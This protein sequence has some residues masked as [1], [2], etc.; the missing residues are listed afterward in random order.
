MVAPGVY[1]RVY[2]KYFDRGDEVLANGNSSSDSWRKG[3]GGFRLDSEASSQNAFTL[4]GDFYSGHNQLPTGGDDQTSGGNLLGRWTHVFS[5]ESN[6]SLQLYYDR[7]H[8]S[9]PV[10]ALVVNKSTL[11]PA[12]IFKDDLDTYDLD[13]QHRF[14]LGGRSHIVWGFGYRFTHDAV[15]N[16]PALAFFPARLDQSLISGFAQDE[17]ALGKD[18][19]L[20][21]GTKLE[22]NDY[23][24]LEVEPSVRLQWAATA[25]QSLW[26]AVSR[27]VRRP[28][29]IDRDLSNGAPPYFVLLA[30]GPDFTS[31]KVTAYE[32]GHR[33]Q[34]GPKVA[35]SLSAFYNDYTDVRSTVFNPKTTFPLF[36]QN[37]LEGETYGFE[38]SADWQALAGWRLHAGYNLLKE[39]LRIKP[40]QSDINNALNETSDP[41]Q[42]FSLRSSLDLPRDM[43][44]DAGLR[45]VDTRPVH[46][47]S[48]P[49][50][51]PSY[52][53]LDVR[54]GWHPV[55]NLELALVGQNLLHDHHPEYGFPSPTRA[56]IQRSVYGKVTW[57]Y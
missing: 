37:N 24:G 17:I 57:R 43:E 50:T 41:E 7:T 35:T 46:Q 28:S 6:L 55:K 19:S 38:F 45:W 32:L 5:D 21:F 44:L 42:H 33:A 31:E 52:F 1:F 13:F 49:G 4:Q 51:L 3:Q 20:T 12:G 40:G 10:P 47:G 54:L 29:R 18:L 26:A 22:H 8:L 30:G 2:G 15:T 25:S 27:A 39:H 16:A 11:A 36:F 14:G 53:E 23:S 34:L 48:T 56:E 9:Q